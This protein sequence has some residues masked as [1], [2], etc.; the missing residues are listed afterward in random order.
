MPLVLGVTGGIGTGKSTVLKMLADLGAEVLSADD[1]ARETLVV[2]TPAYCDAV[3][4]FGRSILLPGGE[5]DRAALADIVFR[6]ADARKALEA[7]THPRIISRIQGHIDRFREN[8]PSP[9]AVLAVE[10]PLLY[11]CGLE[12]T[13]DE[14]LLV[15]A[16]QDTQ[17]GRLTSR[18][19]LSPD[20]A[21]RRIGAQMPMEQKVGRAGWVVRNDGSVQELERSVRIVWEEVRAH[22]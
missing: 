12:A 10:I 8:P 15:A 18:S 21:A 6:N 2:G 9:D 14:V 16:E 11:E 3:E 5:I 19:G 22:H 13:V 20:E 17:I 1:I 4:R 7:I